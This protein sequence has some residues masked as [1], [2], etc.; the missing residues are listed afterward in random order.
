MQNKLNEKIEDL[1]DKWGGHTSEGGIYWNDD[2]TPHPKEA[3]ISELTTLIASERK[4][5]VEGFAKWWNTQCA[6]EG[7]G[8]IWLKEYLEKIK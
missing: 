5:A 6:E 7:I 1:V 2:E 4:D 3:L 8:D